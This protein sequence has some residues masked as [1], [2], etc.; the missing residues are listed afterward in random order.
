M[1][2][3]CSVVPS[4]ETSLTASSFFNSTT[5]DDAS[6]CDSSS[7]SRSLTTPIW[8][9][10]RSEK[11]NVSTCVSADAG[12]CTRLIASCTFCSALAMFVP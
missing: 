12:S 4:K 11:L 7:G 2:S 10:G 1:T 9:T 8:I 3:R 6:R 5:V